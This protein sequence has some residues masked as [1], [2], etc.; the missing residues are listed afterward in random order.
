MVDVEEIL[1]KQCFKKKFLKTLFKILLPPFVYDIIYT[2][3]GNNMNDERRV[4]KLIKESG[5]LIKTSEVISKGI[6][7][8]SLVRLVKKGLIY[9]LE[10]GLY[11]D[12]NKIIIAL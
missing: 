11:I 3:G 6:N 12:S 2:N 4:L 9:R 5:G 8:M 10:R 1:K 7:K